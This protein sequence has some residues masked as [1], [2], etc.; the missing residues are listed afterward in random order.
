MPIINVIENMKIDKK[1]LDY[2]SKLARLK[3]KPEEVQSLSEQLTKI[4]E[5]VEQLNKLD[6]AETEPLVH[7]LEQ[8]NVFR[9]DTNRPSLPKDKALANAPDKDK[10]F[11]RVP[12]VIE[13]L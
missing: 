3:V 10:G 7:T 1:L 13:G 8:T 5:Y 12:K 2:L 9:K 11:F 6:V 4:L